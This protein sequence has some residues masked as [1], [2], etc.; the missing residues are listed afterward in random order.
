MFPVH[1]VFLVISPGPGDVFPVLPQKATSHGGCP[2][3]H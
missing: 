3:S 1:A 2:A